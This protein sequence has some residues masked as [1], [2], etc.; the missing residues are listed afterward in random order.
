MHHALKKGKNISIT[1]ANLEEFLVI[2]IFQ[3]TK[4]PMVDTK[5][6]VYSKFFL[7]KFFKEIKFP[8]SMRNGTFNTSR[9][10]ASKN[11]GDVHPFSQKPWPILQTSKK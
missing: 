1:V 3:E 11:G 4:I 9:C 6:H 8:I 5:V 7:N 2:S 10:R